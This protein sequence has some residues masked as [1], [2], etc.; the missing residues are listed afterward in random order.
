MFSLH[1]P[2]ESTVQRFLEAEARLELTYPDIG[3]TAGETP[4]GYKVNHTRIELGS[5]QAVYDAAVEAL[6]SWDQFGLPWISIGPARAAIKIG[7]VV[8]IV[9]RKF[10]CWWLNS[11]RIVY[12]TEVRGPVERFGF[13]YGTLPAHMGRGEE[14]FLVEWDRATDQV[15]YDILAF[16]QPQHILCKIGYPFFRLSQRQFA[17]G[18]AAA[19][20][21][22]IAAKC[23]LSSQ[24]VAKPA[25]LVGTA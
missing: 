22:A 4:V 7:G 16:S 19:M 3:A 5:G 17:R 15:W 9:A 2:D 8:A 25:R 21:R 23:Q 18:S 14:R 20:R 1:K 10:G 6:R 12:V 13:A 11:C 24:P